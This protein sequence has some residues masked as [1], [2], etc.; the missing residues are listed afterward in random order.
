MHVFNTGL[1]SG[2]V[3]EDTF[4]FQNTNMQ[5]GLLEAKRDW[6]V[7]RD[8]DNSQSF[9]SADDYQSTKELPDR[10]SRLYTPYDARE[11]AQPSVFI[12]DAAGNKTPLNPIAFASRYDKKDVAGFYYLDILN[13]KIGRTGSLAGTLHIY[14]IR[15]TADIDSDRVWEFPDWAHP[16]L[17]FRVA[18]T[19]KG[20]VD[21][22]IINGSQVPFNADDAKTI[23]SRL[24]MWD[25]QLQQQEL[26]V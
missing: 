10:F 22:D 8:F 3:L 24:D 12:V 19:H 1:L 21:Y 14:F 17:P 16:Y 7:L 25:A 18:V 9:T 23:L 20:G 2:T 15:N 6:M 26:G 13:G 5:K 11:G 4:F